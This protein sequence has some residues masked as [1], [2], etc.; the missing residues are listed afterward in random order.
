[1]KLSSP[2]LVQNLNMTT[3]RKIATTTS[4]KKDTVT[5]PMPTSLKGVIVVYRQ[6]SQIM[7]SLHKPI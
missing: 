1:M 5:G 2:V 6:I 3:F 4:K 7:E